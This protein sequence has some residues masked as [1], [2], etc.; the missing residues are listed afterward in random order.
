M[1]TAGAAEQDVAEPLSLPPNPL[2]E[3][4]GSVRLPDPCTMV[5]F[6]ATGDLTA[7]KLM[8]SLYE[9]AADRQLPPGFTIVGFALDDLDDRAFRERI[10]AAMAAL[11]GPQ[12]IDRALW[13]SFAEGLFYVRGRFD[14]PAAYAQLKAKLERVEAQRHTGGNR[15]FYLATPPSFFAVIVRALGKAGMA[16]QPSA[17]PG[18]PHT[19]PVAGGAPWTRVVIEKPFGRDLESAR[20]LNRHVLEVFDERQVFR[21]DHYLGKETV[22]N[23]LALRFA[24]EIFEPIWNRNHVDHVQIAVAESI[25]VEHRGRYYEEAGAL[26]D[27]VQN[28]MMQLLSLVAMEPPATFSADAVRDE[29]VKVLRSI[30]PIAPGEALEKTVRGQYGPGMTGEGP[31]PGYREEPDVA[32]S[33]LTETYVALRLEVENWRWAGVPF[34]LRTGKRL[35]KRVTEISIQFRRV[36]HLL[37]DPASHDPA[38]LEP[39][40]LSIRIQ[41]NEGISLRFGAKV[42]GPAMQVRPVHMDFLYGTAFGGVQREAYERLL[43][44]CMLGDSTLF[45]RRDEVEASWA[46][47]TPIIEGWQAGPPP[48]FPNYAAGTWGPQEAEQL[49]ARDAPGRRW[50][51]L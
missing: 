8:P 34:F 11:H 51:R 19:L 48:S 45:T 27:M 33:S 22:Q 49:I 43:L 10:A 26:R 37:F 36:P 31:A 32:P 9:L 7:R 4:L 23:L 28:H 40:V 21:I 5:I 20:Q 15:I 16:G 39:N 50:L 25:G 17:S 14:D 42:P 46:I 12:A 1:A 41:P 29:K 47:I 2:R 24:N 30:H 6:G 44:D 3:G 18:G 35:P 38:A 13:A